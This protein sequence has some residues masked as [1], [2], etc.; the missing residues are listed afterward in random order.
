MKFEKFDLLAFLL[1]LSIGVIS[2]FVTFEWVIGYSIF[3]GL[4]LA[5]GRKLLNK[6]TRD[7]ND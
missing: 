4:G 6:K 5:V 3:I 2:S 7:R 1:I